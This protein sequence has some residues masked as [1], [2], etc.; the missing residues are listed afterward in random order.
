MEDLMKRTKAELIATINNQKGTIEARDN[1]VNKLKTSA[2]A[3]QEQ[4][5]KAITNTRAIIE[6]KDKE[7]DKW[8]SVAESVSPIDTKKLQAERDYYLKKYEQRTQELNAYYTQHGNLLKVLSG[9]VGQAIELNERLEKDVEAHG[10]E[11]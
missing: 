8:K 1:Q 5:Q 6:V 10:K 9:T 2:A 3:T 11:S 4:H 7:I